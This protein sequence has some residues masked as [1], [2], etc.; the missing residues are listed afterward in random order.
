[1]ALL[2]CTVL[3]AG[4]KINSVSYDQTAEGYLDR[5]N[6][7]KSSQKGWVY[8][9]NPNDSW[10][11]KV[12]KGPFSLYKMQ[13]AQAYVFEHQFETTKDLKM[14]VREER[15]AAFID[16]Y[17]NNKLSS[18]YELKMVQKYLDRPDTTL[19]EAARKVNVRKLKTQEDY[20]AA[21]EIF[22]HMMEAAHKFKTTQKYSDLMSKKYD[23][24]VDDNNKG[25][26]NNTNNPI[27]VFRAKEA[28][29]SIG[30]SKMLT[31]EEVYKNYGD[32]RE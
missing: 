16:V 27:I 17:K 1:M 24:M 11:S 28:L 9:F 6:S 4:S 18:K 2:E 3:K 22:N 8:G 15:V 29:K 7:R 30:D 14:P 12:Y 19:S 20:E 26:Y 23:A 31:V 13:A 5:S 32:V 21:Y 10:D 25:V